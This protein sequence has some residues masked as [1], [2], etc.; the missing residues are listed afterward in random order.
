MKFPKVLAYQYS[1]KAARQPD[2][3]L[4]WSIPEDKIDRL[5]LGFPWRDA[6]SFYSK[7]SRFYWGFSLAGSQEDMFPILDGRWELDVASLEEPEYVLEMATFPTKLDPSQRAALDNLLKELI[8]DPD[9]DFWWEDDIR[10]GPRKRSAKAKK[11]IITEY[12]QLPVYD[13]SEDLTLEDSNVTL[14]QALDMFGFGQDAKPKVVGKMYRLKHKQL[15]LKY[16]P[17]NSDTGDE[18]KFMFLQKCKSVIEE[19]IDS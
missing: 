15:Q 10:A 8:D 12:E 3:T 17:D 2:G 16:H 13:G 9:F 6:I 11:K 7:R 14:K 4:K 5:M 1:L 19:W 18:Q